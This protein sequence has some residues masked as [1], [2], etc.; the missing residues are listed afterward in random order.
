MIKVDRVEE[1]AK[2]PQLAVAE[3]KKNADRIKNGMGRA[4]SAYKNE[5][6]RQATD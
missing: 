3:K 4:L 1:P 6:E 2:L 5:D